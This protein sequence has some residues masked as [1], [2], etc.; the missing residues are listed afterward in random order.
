MSVNSNL[1]RISL[2]QSGTLAL[3]IALPIVY[4]VVAL[5]AVFVY[6]IVVQIICANRFR[7]KSLHSIILNLAIGDL[8]FV[9]IFSILRAVSYANSSSDW[10]LVPEKW[11]KA[12]MYLLRLF[13]FVLA[14]SIVFLCFERV[15]RPRSFLYGMTKLKSGFAISISIWIASA[16]VLIPI[17][18]FQQTISTQS[19]GGYLCYTK[20]ES[21]TLA[22]LGQQPRRLLDFLDIIFRIFLP[23]L[24]MLL[25]I[26]MSICLNR[27]RKSQLLNNSANGRTREGVTLETMTIDITKKQ[28][29]LLV[30]AALYAFTFAF[31]QLPFEIYRSIMLFNI[32]LESKLSISEQNVDFAIEIPLLFLKLLNRC[33]NPLIFVLLADPNSF[34][35]GCFR[36]W[37]CPCL[38][39]CIGCK[40]CWFYDCQRTCISE[41]CWCSHEFQDQNKWVPTGLQTISSY[42][43]RDGDQTITKQ[44]VVSEYEK[45][46]QPFY[47]N[48]ELAAEIKEPK[49]CMNVAY[50]S[51]S[52]GGTIERRAKL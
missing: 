51:D 33:I 29:S 38:P 26:L 19:Y 6:L 37:C 21:V 9:G 43:Y 20:D 30:M 45:G 44:K 5:L 47:K 16:Y 27:P 49:G 28:G 4:A 23:I 50:E 1:S 2:D 12:E 8:A 36:F 40:S 3:R 15:A 34:K 7:H 10:I 11:C 18:L 35:R 22:W 17:L 31:C 52:D 13:D 42:S 32:D 39:G 46:V 48:P 14:Y 24:L 41:L 25:F